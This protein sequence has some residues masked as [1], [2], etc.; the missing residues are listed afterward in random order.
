MLKHDHRMNEKPYLIKYYILLFYI[1]KTYKRFTGPYL[2]VSIMFF[3]YEF[4]LRDDVATWLLIET[5]ITNY[6]IRT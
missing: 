3:R 1:V 6:R 4:K 5:I 2:I